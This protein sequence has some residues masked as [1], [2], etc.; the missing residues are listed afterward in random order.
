MAVR[1][2]DHSLARLFKG[3]LLEVVLEILSTPCGL[4]LSCRMATGY[5][6]L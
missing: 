4:L 1:L 5:I 6:D 2:C 3:V